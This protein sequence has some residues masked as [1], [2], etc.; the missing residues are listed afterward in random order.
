MRVEM[1]GRGIGPINAAVK[2][3]GGLHVCLRV[4]YGSSLT[5]ETREQRGTN[6]E[7]I[8]L[9]FLFSRTPAITNTAFGISTSVVL[10]PCL[11]EGRCCLRHL[12]ARLRNISNTV[13]VVLG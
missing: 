1:S 12:V 6:L 9:F 11:V 3:D 4:R 10:F 7:R 2:S 13:F 5:W 8:A